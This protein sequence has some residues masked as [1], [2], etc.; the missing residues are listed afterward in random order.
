MPGLLLSSGGRVE[1]PHECRQQDLGHCPDTQTY[2][3]AL[4]VPVCPVMAHEF[5]HT[6]GLGHAVGW[7][8]GYQEVMTGYVPKHSQLSPFEQQALHELYNNH[9]AH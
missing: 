1:L 4:Y 7:P 5:G 6:A 8:P 9:I 2:H 3:E